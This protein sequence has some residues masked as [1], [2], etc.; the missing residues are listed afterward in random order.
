MKPDESMMNATSFERAATCVVSIPPSLDPQ[1]PIL[2]GLMS[3]LPC[4]KRMAA[5]ASLAKSSG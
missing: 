4:R 2:R 3:F 5:N 1:K